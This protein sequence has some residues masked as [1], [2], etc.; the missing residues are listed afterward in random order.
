MR[1]IPDSLALRLESSQLFTRILPPNALPLLDGY[2]TAHSRHI[3]APHALLSTAIVSLLGG[4]GVISTLM[5]AF[6]RAYNRPKAFWSSWR[7]RIVSTL[8]V[9]LSLVPLAVVSAL[10]IGGHLI[11]LWLRAWLV[12]DLRMLLIPLLIVL[13]WAV[14]VAGS[15]GVIAVIY[16]FGSPVRHPIGRAVPGAVL[17]TAL[18]FPA[19]LA[20]GW[21]VTRFTDYSRV[22]GPLGAGVALLIW[23]YLIA[24]SV[25]VGAEYNAQ[26]HPA[27]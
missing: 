14:A 8:L 12:P 17:A 15:I 16:R 10:L 20:F 13:R 5:E 3:H 21:Y 7:K 19:T 27:R 25:I 26:R 4:A 23:L 1:Q 18:W 2:F 9:P 6:R 11:T 24:L 22:Y